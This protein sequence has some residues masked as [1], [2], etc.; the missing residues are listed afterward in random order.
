MMIDLG[1][2]GSSG[3]TKSGTAIVLPEK[4]LSRPCAHSEIL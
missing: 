3:G 1:D 4:S 2:M